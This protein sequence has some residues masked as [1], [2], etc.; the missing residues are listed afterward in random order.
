MV[1]QLG[2]IVILDN[3][4]KACDLCIVD[5]PQKIIVKSERVN[6]RGYIVVEVDDMTKCTACN[7]CAM[8]CPDRAID[9]YRFDKQATGLR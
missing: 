5:C 8:V 4:C 2:Y 3:R 6:R 7:L 9:V 1:K